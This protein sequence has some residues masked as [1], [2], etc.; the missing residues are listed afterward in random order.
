MPVIDLSDIELAEARRKLLDSGV[1]LPEHQ[2][3]AAVVLFKG[4]VCAHLK[5]GPSTQ[6]AH[7]WTARLADGQIELRRTPTGWSGAARMR[8]GSFVPARGAPLGELVR[9]ED[10][11]TDSEFLAR[12]A[13][14]LSAAATSL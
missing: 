10:W 12:V 8:S 11:S 7:S 4:D 14:A 6:R 5:F 2:E 13:E 1:S 9:I 3:R